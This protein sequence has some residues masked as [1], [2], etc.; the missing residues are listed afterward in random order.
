MLALLRDQNVVGVVLTCRY[1]VCLR[2]GSYADDLDDKVAVLVLV[3][4]I[5]GEVAVGR[6]KSQSYV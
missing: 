5:V 1:S 6:V 4:G 3:I 2:N